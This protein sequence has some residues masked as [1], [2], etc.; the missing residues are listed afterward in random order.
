MN[1]ARIDFVFRDKSGAN[2]TY[3]FIRR[4]KVQELLESVE[5]LGPFLAS[6]AE[7]LPGPEDEDEDDDEDDED[8]DDDDEPEGEPAAP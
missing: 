1:I 8:D 6:L 2:R 3:S 4:I 5:P 7:I